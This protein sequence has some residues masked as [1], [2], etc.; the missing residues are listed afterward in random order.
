[1]TKQKQNIKSKEHTRRAKRKENCEKNLAI[2]ALALTFHFRQAQTMKH[3]HNQS[4][5]KSF[6]KQKNK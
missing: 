1:M 6:P 2:V 5:M 3:A 4:E